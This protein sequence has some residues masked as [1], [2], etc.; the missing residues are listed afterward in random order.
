M[1][2]FISTS[3]TLHESSTLIIVLKS[4]ENFVV[5]EEMREIKMRI[6]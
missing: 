4:G 3:I 2:I 6:L 5:A 1:K